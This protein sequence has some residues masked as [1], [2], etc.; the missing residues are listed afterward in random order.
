MPFSVLEL[1]TS[2]LFHVFAEIKS[3]QLSSFR[4]TKAAA[5]VWNSD[6]LNVWP[7]KK[8]AVIHNGHQV[9]VLKDN[10]NKL[11]EYGQFVCVYVCI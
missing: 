1:L 5:F 11:R 8:D 9:P 6:R 4:A 7:Y 2:L 3:C 10:D